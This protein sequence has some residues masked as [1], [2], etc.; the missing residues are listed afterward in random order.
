[1][2]KK[3]VAKRITINLTSVEAQKLKKY[4]SSTGRPVT[5]VIRQL[6][7]FLKVE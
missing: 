3:W 7:R 1:M 5:D 6:I 4:C 2:K